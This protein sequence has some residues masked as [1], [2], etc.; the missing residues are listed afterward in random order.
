MGSPFLAQI[1]FG[2]HALH[3]LF[4]TLDIGTVE[5]LYTTVD[6]V[7]KKFG[8]ELRNKTHWEMLKGKLQQFLTNYK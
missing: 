6:E 3:N 8:V 4:P 5:Y 7:S 2:D 1:S